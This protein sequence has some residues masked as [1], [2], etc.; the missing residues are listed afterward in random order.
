M[1]QTIAIE[2]VIIVLL[3]IA[4]GVFAM[5]EIA[6]VSA[7]KAKLHH[8]ARAG[9]R[10][11]ASALRLAEN[12]DRFLSTIQ[13]GI[14][15]IGVFAGAFGGATIAAQIDDYL[16]TIPELAPYSEAIGVGVVVIG[17]TYLSLIIGELVPKRLALNAPE[18]IAATVAPAMHLLSRIA[19]P[20]VAFLG[21]STRLVLR[22]LRVKPRKESPVTPEE[23]R[24]L[25]SQGVAG[26][27]IG[28]QERE[29][30]DR[31]LRLA[32]RSVRAVMTPR[33]ETEWLDARK[34]LDELRRQAAVS[35][36]HRFPLATDRIDQI[37]GIVSL[38]DLWGE[39]IRTTADLER[40]AREPL[41]V[42][43]TTSALALLQRFRETRN[44]LGIVIDEYG[45]VEGIVTPTDIFEALVGELPE[46]GEVYEPMIVK[47]SD[48][49]W[50][51]DASIDL[52]EFK[53]VTSTPSL[54]SQKEEYQTLAGYLIGRAGRIPRLGDIVT[55]GEL[56]FE[57]ME[58]DGRR[59][60]RILVT[61]LPDSSL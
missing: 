38:K 7:R 44:H 60:D 56:Q 57:I 52:E 16:E 11:A 14:T 21:A 22:I 8:L 33:V 25:L 61:R 13:I 28:L 26:G 48:G 42:P 4:N 35:L 40:H 27:T 39:E 30:L 47:R 31:A 9:S 58:V 54:P 32:N 6:V 17:I 45:G 53:A 19:T 29:I 10:R 24:V 18:R 41:F 15:L 12:P 43:E 34:T 50:S 36:H 20:A 46:A 49:S 23:L 37:R 5:S 3:V 1:F 2:I 59:I 55:V 51:L